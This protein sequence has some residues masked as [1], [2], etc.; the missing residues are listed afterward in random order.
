MFCAGHALAGEETALPANT[1][2]AQGVAGLMYV[3]VVV[4]QVDAVA[5][6]ALIFQ[7]A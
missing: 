6:A 7:C 3:I 1:G 2:L 5:H 4:K